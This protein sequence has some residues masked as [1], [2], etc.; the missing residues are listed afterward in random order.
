MG[1]S[2]PN[3]LVLLVIISLARFNFGDRAFRLGKTIEMVNTEPIGG[4]S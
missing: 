2:V 3:A 4:L 1:S